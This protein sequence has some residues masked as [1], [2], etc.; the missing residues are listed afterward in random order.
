MRTKGIYG[1]LALLLMVAFLIYGCGDD[2][3]PP[4]PGPEPPP[5]PDSTFSEL[6]V[7]LD[8]MI[9][10]MANDPETPLDN[11]DFSALNQAFKNYESAYPGHDMASF[12]VAITSLLMLT[13][14]EDLNA[15]IDTIIAM[16][17]SGM[18]KISVPNPEKMS[19]RENF[20]AFPT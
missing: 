3:K 4:G 6:T 1:I 9:E 2:D 20:F 8:E 16:D 12:G 19:G 11:F 13:T 5:H 7:T 18:L 15:L 14:S 17:E 10:A